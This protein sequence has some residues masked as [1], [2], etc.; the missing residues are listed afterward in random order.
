[1]NE[2][3]VM[4]AMTMT[5]T[6]L[7]GVVWEV[8]PQQRRQSEGMTPL[9]E[10]GTPRGLISRALAARVAIVRTLGTQTPGGDVLRL[11]QPLALQAAAWVIPRHLWGGQ[12]SRVPLHYQICCV[13]PASDNL[14]SEYDEEI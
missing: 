5:M 2:G 4:M 7:V 6:A 1:M 14:S 8:R 9:V 12:V 10:E 3:W 13:V 11:H